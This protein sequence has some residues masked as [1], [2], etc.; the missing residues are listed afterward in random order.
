MMNPTTF[1]AFELDEG[2]FVELLPLLRDNVGYVLVWGQAAV[3]VDAPD[4]PVI[5][6]Y[7]QSRGL[8]LEMIVNTH[9][10]Y[11]HVGGNLYLQEHTN[12]RVAGP[13]SSEIPGLSTP[14]RDGDRLDV[15]PFRFEVLATPGH[16]LS[17]LSLFDPQYGICFCG[18][19]L[20]VGGC[21]RLF[22]GSPAQMWNS[23]QRLRGLP[24]HTALFCGH[25]YAV[26]NYTFAA[27]QFPEKKVF[28]ERLEKARK[29]RLMPTTVREEKESNLMWMADQPGIA[30]SLGLSGCAPEDV[31]ARI[32]ELR[33]EF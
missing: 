17:D 25:N 4:G 3:V 15:G 20:F 33:N 30:D 8:R 24:D 26:D 23:L 32:R 29:G 31:F 13:D 19:S 22:E 14:L 6:H 2:V 7:L 28:A 12:C 5:H 21:G 10:H 18:D 16:T 11:D 1:S 9:S 27:R